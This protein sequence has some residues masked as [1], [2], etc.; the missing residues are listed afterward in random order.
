MT[1]ALVS[2]LKALSS[3]STLMMFVSPSPSIYRVHK[4]KTIGEVSILPLV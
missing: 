1:S 4:T 3:I 2:V